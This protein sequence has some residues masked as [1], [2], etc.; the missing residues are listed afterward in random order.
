MSSVR[1]HEQD[2]LQESDKLA[3]LKAAYMSDLKNYF[4]SS[5]PPSLRLQLVLRAQQSGNE[6]FNFAEGL[7]ASSDLLGAHRSALW[8]QG[9]AESC[10]AIL[11]TY[12]GHLDFLVTAFAAADPNIDKDK[13]QPAN[14][15]FANMQRMVTTYLTGKEIRTLK[16]AFK[17]AGLPTYGFKNEAKQF[18]S[19]TLQ[20]WLSFIFGVI[21]LSLLLLIAFLRPEPSSFQYNIFRT[22]MAL[23]GGAAAA[24]IPGFIE[25]K[26]GNWLRAGGGLAVF[27][28]LYFYVPKVVDQP[29]TKVPHTETMP[30]PIKS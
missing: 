25:L 15:A 3:Q 29:G 7:V 2:V 28:V 9:F 14:T 17:S 10:A 12:P 21:F 16:S 6:Y 26:F 4:N 19:K 30:L 23:A 11:G 24:V 22:V 8:A 1:T 27:L 20:T 5:D 18:M 13:I